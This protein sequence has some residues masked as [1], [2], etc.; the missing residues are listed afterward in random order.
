[1]CFIFYRHFFTLWASRSH[2]K[3]FVVARVRL[4][5]LA[6]VHYSSVGHCLNLCGWVGGWPRLVNNPSYFYLFF[7]IGF[8]FS[9]KDLSPSCESS[10]AISSSL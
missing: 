4:G 6:A 3:A 5:R 1:M 2:D 10:E 7:Q 9:K 8:R